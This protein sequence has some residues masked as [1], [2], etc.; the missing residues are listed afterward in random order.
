MPIYEFSCN[1]CKSLVSVF[2]RSMNSPVNG[3]C[4][5]CGGTDLTRLVSQVSIPHFGRGGGD[6]FDMAIATHWRA[7]H[8]LAA[9]DKPEVQA[10]RGS[11]HLVM[12]GANIALHKPDVRAW[13]AEKLA[14]A[15]ATGLIRYLDNLQDEQDV[16]AGVA[17]GVV[18]VGDD[19]IEVTGSV[20]ERVIH[21]GRTVV[22]GPVVDP[23]TFWPGFGV[24]VVAMSRPRVV[25]RI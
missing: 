22:E 14:N 11:P 19:R 7:A 9:A 10:V 2:V 17:V 23:R 24:R 6:D 8:K 21:E 13:N 4:E 5:S 12:H 15:A 3:K 18:Q 16:P 20:E 25:F 1:N